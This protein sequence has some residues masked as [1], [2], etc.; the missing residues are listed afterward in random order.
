M[1][2][3]IG[4]KH[5]NIVTSTALDGI[6]ECTYDGQAVTTLF[7]LLYAHLESALGASGASLLALPERAF[8]KAREVEMITWYTDRPGVFREIDALSQE[9]RAKAEGI[10]RRELANA[11]DRSDRASRDML[12]IAL[13][14]SGRDSIFFDGNAVVL[15]NWG[16]RSVA[17]LNGLPAGG[18]PLTPYLPD[19]FV[20]NSTKGPDEAPEPQTD[21][22]L[23]VVPVGAEIRAE[24]Q[25]SA[26]SSA[27]ENGAQNEP[28]LG[29]EPRQLPVNVTQAG[30][31]GMTD[32]VPL[33]AERTA[34]LP[35]MLWLSGVVFLFAIFLFYLL[36]PGNLIYPT[37]S[38]GTLSGPAA[39]A[40]QRQTNDALRDQITRLRTGLGG[41]VCT[42]PNRELLD[43]IANVPLLPSSFYPEAVP[44][45]QPSTSVPALPD[46][47]SK[48]PMPSQT[49]GDAPVILAG[50]EMINRLETGTVIIVGAQSE[51]V[52]I[53]SGLLVSP[54]HVLTN[55]HVVKDVKSGTLLVSNRRIGAPVRARVVART[56]SSDIGTEDFALLETEREM[57]QTRLPIAAT[58]ERLDSVIAA[59]YPSFVVET[60]PSFVQ[61]FREGSVDRLGDIQLAVTRGEITAVQ[62]GANSVT[63]LVHSATISPGNSG[64]PLVDRCGRVV[65]IN[66]FIRTNGEGLLRLNVALGAADAVRFLSSNGIAL[67]PATSACADLPVAKAHPG[68]PVL[69]AAAV[70]QGVPPANVNEEPLAPTQGEQQ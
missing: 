54:H 60:D 57:D 61:A 63:T 47:A 18:C 15:A 51:G 56:E 36:W 66:T 68:A 34:I 67:A 50:S 12:S 53:G 41:N 14:I 39:G 3:V 21:N 44:L 29:E 62:A 46:E 19:G 8:S 49:S 23:P 7:P 20:L 65:G 26:S 30:R 43:G 59:G 33:M 58:A 69:E 37:A 13:N 2:S 5:T 10:L 40:A 64:G 27:D 35:A 6:V 9:E 28:T 22:L 1:A 42:A 38:V 52:S 25:T 55:A 31:S 11:I 45:S 24:S 17:Q 70:P 48:A 32:A 16:F 4:S